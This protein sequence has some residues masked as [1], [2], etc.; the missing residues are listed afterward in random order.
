MARLTSTA[1]AARAI[2]VAAIFAACILPPPVTLE[3]GDDQRPYI[4]ANNSVPKATDVEINLSCDTCSFT[5]DEEDP[6]SVDTLSSHWFWDYD[7]GDTS[8]F[9][10][11]SVQPPKNGASR[12]LDTYAVDVNGV[13]NVLPN[14]TTSDVHTLSVVVTDRPF[15]STADQPINQAIDPTAL[16]T[17]YSWTVRFAR[18]SPTCDTSFCSSSSSQ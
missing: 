8:V 16:S 11:G 7:L 12:A 10:S 18:G 14:L 13:F 15:P 4:N 6:D 1:R 5:L 3:Q 2:F 17:T 9:F